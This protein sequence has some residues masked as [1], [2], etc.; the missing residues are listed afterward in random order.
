MAD[1]IVVRV[2]ERIILNF[3]HQTPVNLSIDR[4]LELAADI[5][6]LAAGTVRDEPCPC[7]SS[8]A[9]GACCLGSGL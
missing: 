3:G 1:Q 9:Y 2:G 4:A 5:A 7:G 6:T 8:K